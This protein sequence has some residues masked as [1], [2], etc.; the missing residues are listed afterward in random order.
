MTE[1]VPKPTKKA[2]VQRINLLERAMES[3]TDDELPAKTEELK[4]RLKKRARHMATDTKPA[5]VSD[6][7]ALREELVHLNSLFHDATLAYMLKHDLPLNR[8][9]YIAMNRGAGR[10]AEGVDR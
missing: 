8:E 9:T 10:S 1:P 5:T 2:T 7:S 3:L 6:D 4:A